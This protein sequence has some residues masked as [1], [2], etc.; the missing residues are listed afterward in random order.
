M[1]ARTRMTVTGA[2]L[3]EE[4]NLLLCDSIC[5]M[6]G[7]D[8]GVSD[9]PDPFLGRAGGKGTGVRGLRE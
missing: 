3:R 1:L 9:K 5:V 7:K 2:L 8:K 6:P 4:A